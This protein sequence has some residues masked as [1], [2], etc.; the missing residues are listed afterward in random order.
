[1]SAARPSSFTELKRHARIAECLF[2]SIRPWPLDSKS[3]AS[4]ARLVKKKKERRYKNDGN[5]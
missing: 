5:F 2:L 4:F 1:M 3:Q